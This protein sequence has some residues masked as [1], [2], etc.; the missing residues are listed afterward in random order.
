MD[1]QEQKELISDVKKLIRRELD[2]GR[3]INSLA[4]DIGISESVLARVYN[5]AHCIGCGVSE[6]MVLRIKRWFE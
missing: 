1:E 5:T 2:Q 3:T 4:R 6:D